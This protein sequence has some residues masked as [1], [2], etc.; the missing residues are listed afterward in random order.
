MLTCPQCKAM[1]LPADT[2]CRRCGE[3]LPARD[4]DAPEPPDALPGTR[5]A[6]NYEILDLLGE[7]AMG[8]VYR[9]KQLSLDKVVAIKVLHKHLATDTKLA[10]RFHREARAA[11]RLSHPNSVQIID[12]GAAEDGTL[13]IAMEFLEGEDLQSIIEREMPLAP[14]RIALLLGQVLSALDEA[15]HAGIIHRDLKPENVLVLPAARGAGERVKV[16]DFG[17]AKIQES[18][19]GSAI[20][21]AGFVCGTP[22]Y[23]APEQARGDELDS[24]ADIYSAGIILYQMLT[25]AVPFTSDTALGTITKQLVEPLIPPRKKRPDL[26]IPEALEAVALGALA[27][28]REKRYATAGQMADAL[29]DAVRSLGERAS[30]PIPSGRPPPSEPAGPV[31]VDGHSRTVD[32]MPA[33]KRTRAPLFAVG[34]VVLLGLAAAG[35][36]TALG[37]GTTT[38]SANSPT[39]DTDAGPPPQVIDD[40]SAIEGAGS[41]DLGSDADAGA[42]DVAAEGATATGAATLRAGRRL[43]GRV[44]APPNAAVAVPDP[45]PVVEPPPVQRPPTPPATPSAFEEGRRLFLANDVP[46]AIARFEQAAREAPSNPRVQKELGRAYMRAGNVPRAVTAYRRYLDL[47]P[48]ASDRAI[49][50]QILTQSGG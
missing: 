16:C 21:M 18:D 41:A 14:A 48:Q 33:Q 7:G 13:Y 8:R 47:A 15:H 45:P 9:A 19:G 6:G 44:E 17:I 30:L 34:G 46:G 29:S 22:E 36:Y 40:P 20:T 28:D 42:L 1:V 35:A 31:E 11:S 43:P 25:G 5:I 37:S 39:T 12:F 2:V 24:R 50:E 26:R 4:S 3:T 27:K 38:N 32:A 23:M 49:I 10:K